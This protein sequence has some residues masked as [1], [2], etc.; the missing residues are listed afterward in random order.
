MSWL[1]VA[2]YRLKALAASP[3]TL[4]L[5]LLVPVA[6]SILA[7]ALAG[8]QTGSIPVAVVDEDQS[9]YAQMVL[10]RLSRRPV[11]QVEAMD[12]EAALLAVQRRRVEVALVMTPGF[13]ERIRQG[14]R[15][16]L[17]ELVKAPSSLAAEMTGE[18]L[19]SEV[20]RLA[21][22]V[23]AANEVTN[24]Y[25]KRGL[26]P[27]SE[28]QRL[29]SEVW[30]ETDSHW[31]PEPLMTMTYREWSG[32][33]DLSPVAEDALPWKA[34]EVPFSLLASLV[35]FNTLLGAGGLVRD[36]AQGMLPRV[37]TT[38]AGLVRYQAGS[39]LAVALLGAATIALSAFGLWWVTGQP[40]ALGLSAGA[41]LVA[42][43]VAVS[44]LSLLAGLVFRTDQQLQAAVPLV[45]LA[46][47]I[48]GSGAGVLGDIS[49][50]FEQMAW[51]TPQG[52]MLSGLRASALGAGAG[53]YL[54]PVVV[55][56]VVGLVSFAVSW[57]LGLR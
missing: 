56:L 51:F 33:A 10:T 37:R 21:A 14:E 45:T 46:T 50:R 49:A 43:L 1:A 47:G 19:A 17:V 7:G 35:L 48:L 2:Y 53:G 25:G 36:R 31:E 34:Q 55:L 40:P 13:E 12:R 32:S 39:G 6:G 27:T 8:G 15:E 41:V 44:G 20:V 52:W 9:D 26:V 30:A 16:A 29:W 18:Y 28:K 5:M 4:L 11:L 24:A 54:V 42:Y 38:R 57:R 23:R 22:N 3:L